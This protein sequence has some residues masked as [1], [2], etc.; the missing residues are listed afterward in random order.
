MDVSWKA[1][2]YLHAWDHQHSIEGGIACEQ[3]LRQ[4][5]LDYSVD[6]LGRIDAFLDGLRAS[7]RDRLVP[8][9][10]WAPEY[11]RLLRLLAFYVGEV[12][13]RSSQRSPV[14]L[15]FEQFVE[16][17]GGDPAEDCLEHSVV[18]IDGTVVFMPLVSI[19]A[20]VTEDSGRKSVSTSARALI[21][22]DWQLPPQAAQPLPPWPAP[23]WV[24]E[25]SERIAAA[26][27]DVLKAYEMDE[28]FWASDDDLHRVF[29]HAP[30]LLRSGRVVWGALVQAN[31]GLFD[32]SGFLADGGAPAEVLYDPLGRATRDGLCEVARAVF[33][34]K[35]QPSE[36]PQTAQVSEH[37]AAETLRAFGMAV[38][39]QLSSYPLQLSTTWVSSRYL[40]LRHLVLPC[41]PLLVS[42]TM[43]GV[44]LPVPSSFWPEDLLQEWESAAQRRPR[45]PH[46]RP[47]YVPPRE[48]AH[49]QPSSLVEEAHLYFAGKGVPQDMDK[50][51]SAWEKAAQQGSFT[52]LRQLAQLYEQGLGVERDVRKA[53]IHY[54]L[55][56]DSGCS[57][58]RQHAERLKA[59]MQKGAV[60]SSGAQPDSDTPDEWCDRAL[61]LLQDQHAHRYLDEMLKLLKRGARRNH[62]DSL[63]NLGVIYHNG[64][65]LPRQGRISIG[66]LQRAAELGH[67]VASEFVAKRKRTL[68]GL[69]EWYF[70]VRDAENR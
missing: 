46:D 44:V 23:A 64:D 4:Y 15:T 56:A 7:H 57:E 41:V 62:R 22:A 47:L 31:N 42:Q 69:W 32:L 39:R 12:I 53:I 28:P 50:A 29:I 70:R 66:Y 49:M 68:I 21:A 37:L 3:E 26:S 17:Y 51:R 48:L 54:E 61:K 14:W 18:L 60:A 52:A 25:T 1:L 38:P 55:A 63:F 20:R 11:H 5:R 8:G 67:P 16:Q 35:G 65:L 45:G 33:A 36:D 58:S 19:V 43:P 2:Q 24:T 6:S 27:V 40:H 9:T 30:E 10:V 59:Q 34:C 13:A